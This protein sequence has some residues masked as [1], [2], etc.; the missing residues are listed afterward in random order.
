V[1]SQCF[2]AWPASVPTARGYVTDLLG[3]VHP[4]LCQTAALLVSELATN[5]VRHSGAGEFSIQVEYLASEN[6]LWVGVGDAGRGEPILRNPPVTD[7]HGRGLQLVATLADRWGARRRHDTG[8]KTIW[9]ELTSAP[10]SPG[11]AP[12]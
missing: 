9:F 8:E 1:P 11:H 7:E 12:A 2:P 6:R 4:A 3:H 10:P 5:A